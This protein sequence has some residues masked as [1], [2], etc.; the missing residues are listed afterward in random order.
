MP[1]Y[2]NVSSLKRMLENKVVEPGQSVTS[3]VYFDENEIGLLKVSDNPIFNPILLARKI[4]QEINIDIPKK[5]KFH[6]SVCKYTIHF[7][8]MSGEVTIWFN[9]VKNDPPLILYPGA[10]WNIR[11]FNR[12]IDRLFITS[13]GAFE[14]FLMIEKL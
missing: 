6:I 2:K 12:T 3:E 1:T 7:A 5:D 9:S 10:R 13:D 11:C 4:T 8:V 14:M